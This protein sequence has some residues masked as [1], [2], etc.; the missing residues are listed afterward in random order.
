MAPALLV[1]VFGFNVKP[2]HSADDMGNE[3]PAACELFTI[4]IVLT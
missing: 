2:I 1:L 3:S 4:P